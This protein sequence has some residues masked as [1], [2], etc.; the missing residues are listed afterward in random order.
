MRASSGSWFEIKLITK[1]LDVVEFAAIAC[2][3]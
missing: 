1:H 3:A 2:L